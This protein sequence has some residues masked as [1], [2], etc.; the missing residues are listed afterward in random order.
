M[1]EHSAA[2]CSQ[3][4]AGL[5]DKMLGVS[6]SGIGGGFLSLAL[7]VVFHCDSHFLVIKLV[8]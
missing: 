5:L 8:L 7:M 3:Q 2:D 4:S 6:F 1:I